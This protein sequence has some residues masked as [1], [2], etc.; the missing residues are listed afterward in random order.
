MAYLALDI[1]GTNTRIAFIEVK[2]NKPKIVKLLKTYT[3]NIT[4][5]AEFI[6]EF[7]KNNAKYAC[8]GF[9][10]PV[11][12]NKARLTNGELEI[13]VNDLKKKT[14]LK[15]LYLINDFHAIGLGV[16]YLDKKEFLVLNNGIGFNNNVE[17]VVGPGTGLGKAYIINNKV[18][19]CEG[20][21]TT[22]GIEDIQDYALLDYL[23]DKNKNL[24]N[25]TQVYYEDVVSGNGLI[26]IYDHLEIKTNMKLNLKLRNLIKAEP[27]N[28]AKI[29]TKYSSKDKL[30]DMTLHIFTK[31]YA[32][33]VRDSALNLI[34]SKVYLAGG[35]SEAISPYLKKYF[36][37]EFLK[38]RK[39]TNLL[40]KVHI[41]VILNQE[42]GLIGAGSVAAKLNNEV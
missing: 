31:F 20:G 32:R 12:G 9:A 35:I 25:G 39:Y 24:K 10:G 11:L 30:C 38:H 13:N 34:S 18:Y 15:E 40:K 23:K 22:L 4:N 26:D 27:V 37:S 16:K 17:M 5:L 28:K 21:L 29:I 33:F 7:N 2:N 8:I 41:S 42:V 3:K 6:K 36:M 14:N 19:P 1:G